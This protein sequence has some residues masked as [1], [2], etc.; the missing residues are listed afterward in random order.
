[1]A[2]LFSAYALKGRIGET[3]LASLATWGELTKERVSGPDRIL[4]GPVAFAAGVMRNLPLIYGPN[5]ASLGHSGWGGSGGLGDPS[6]GLAAA[7][8]MNRQGSHLLADARRARLI[9]A[10]YGCV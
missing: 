10:L 6:I 9:E 3:R 5:P 4:P 1:M 7:Y 8:V 2:R